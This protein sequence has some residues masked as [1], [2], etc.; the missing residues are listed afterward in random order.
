MWLKPGK[1]YLFGRA[2][3]DGVRFAI[4]HK[5]VSRKHFVINIDAVREEDVGQVHA[6]TKITVADL[7]SKAGTSLDGELLK[8]Q[9]RELKSMVHSI[10]PGTCPH[11]L[12]I[13]WIPYVLTF[14][15]LK[16]EIKNGALQSKQERVK[17]L[18]IKLINDYLAGQTTHVVAQKR[19]TA[20]GLQALIE[21]KYIVTEA[22]IDRLVYAAAPGDLVEEEYPCALEL[23]FDR[24]WPDESA[25]L[26]PAGKERTGKP[27]E[28]Y[29]PDPARS[30]VFEK[31]TFFFF[32]QS[33]YDTLFP[34]ITMGHGKA[35]L[36]KPAS[37]KATVP[38]GLT[39]IRTAIG[40]SGKAIIVK[41][42]ENDEAKTWISEYIED[43]CM[44]LGLE[45]ASQSDLLDAVLSNDASQLR[46]PQAQAN[47]SERAGSKRSAAVAHAGQVIPHAGGT[48]A[49]AASALSPPPLSRSASG[50]SESQSIQDAPAGGTQQSAD[51]NPRPRKK[52]R[53]APPKK[54]T[55]DDDFNPEA[56]QAYE[57]EDEEE[58]SAP[59][60]RSQRNAINHVDDSDADIKEEMTPRARRRKS[61][62]HVV[63]DSDEELDD[64][65]PAA[66]AQRREK[67]QE[68]AEARRRGVP[69]KPVSQA[70]TSSAKKAEKEPKLLDVRGT[71]RAQREAE[72]EATKKE[73]EELDV[74]QAEDAERKGP[75]NLVQIKEFNLPVRKKTAQ[76]D[77]RSA[78]WKPEWEGRKNFKG[79]RRARDAN[80]EPHQPRRK[81]IVPVAPIE[82]RTYGQ[83]DSYWEKTEKEKERAAKEKEKER[84]KRES[85]RSQSQKSRS[86]RSATVQ[87]ESDAFSESE[88]DHDDVSPET[89]RLQKEA[90]G[91]LDHPIDVEAPRQTRRAETQTQSSK[92]T[93]STASRNT[94]SAKRPASSTPK[95]RA[96][97]AKKQKTLPVS[98]VHGSDSDE[99]ED[100]S[101][102]MKFQFGQARKL[103]ASGK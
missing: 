81:I 48:G 56:I 75:A 3:K 45:A 84:K 53:F 4:D 40:K 16:K 68:E 49:L 91:V 9:T 83:G 5:T 103:R 44:G 87:E 37:E 33:Q 78:D 38:E 99:Q 64:L 74:M 100:D 51:D 54:A 97:T 17:E 29:K 95:G 76:N 18:D 46:Q 77:Y 12:V 57:E 8:D 79:F 82:K 96:A 21:G 20:K 2:K 1:R 14:S 31:C 28:A 63:E 19:N 34:A 73:R 59:Q 98:V 32:D 26:P 69:L 55:F 27:A 85:Q 35:L 22:Y 42:N 52:A 47:A 89:A 70:P 61:P 15:L 41:V 43:V 66:A 88:S 24:A 11:E 86:Q 102:D 36:F 30:K 65:L 62:E 50:V 72:E 60:K 7:K 67:R 71:V 13:S 23:D 6:R 39:F 25:H 10:R 80:G 58:I 93:T 94:K 101:D 92:G 90:E